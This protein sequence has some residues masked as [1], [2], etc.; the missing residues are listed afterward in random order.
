MV[1]RRIL[2]R[3]SALALSRVWKGSSTSLLL[4]PSFH[5]LAS[6]WMGWGV[7][8]LVEHV[9]HCIPF[10]NWMSRECVEP[11]LHYGT[12]REREN[13]FNCENIVLP[14]WTNIHK[15]FFGQPPPLYVLRPGYYIL[16][17]IGFR[18]SIRGMKKL[19]WRTYWF[20]VL[21]TEPSLLIR[22]GILL[23]CR[24]DYKLRW[25][26]YSWWGCF[27]LFQHC[28]PRNQYPW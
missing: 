26:Y 16:L 13:C 3:S 24:P 11:P 27:M 2:I 18:G 9:C 20:F 1:S 8:C 15:V 19:I 10:C 7:K 25:L 21:L 4:L 5:V 12:Q 28:V 14:H 17:G 6:R 22:S 23:D